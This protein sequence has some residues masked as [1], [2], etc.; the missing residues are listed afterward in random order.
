MKSSG[1]GMQRLNRISMAAAAAVSLV[2][3][4]PELPVAEAAKMYRYRNEQGVLVI[5]HTVPAGAAERG[6]E[7]LAEDGRVLETVAPGGDS[8]AGA[9]DVDGVRLSAEQLAER[10]KIDRYLLTSYSSVAD[11]EAVKERRLG[12]V[13]REIGIAETQLEEL[14]RAREAV[15]ERAANLQRR[16]KP[17]TESVLDALADLDERELKV[18]ARLQERQLQHAEL[19]Q[20]YDAYVARFKALQAERSGQSPADAA[21]TAATAPASAP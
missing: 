5:D 15:Q 21:P 19:A 13:A 18:R 6:Y 17:V 7:I 3:C 10:E 1:G 11:I 2:L 8:P 9:G 16:G 14:A 4:W 20:H 12:E